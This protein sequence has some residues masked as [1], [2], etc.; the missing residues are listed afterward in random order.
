[1][2][3]DFCALCGKK[4]GL[5]HHHLIPRSEDGT[6]EPDN[7]LTL[8]EEHHEFIHQIRPGTWNNHTNL[9]KQGIK[10]SQEIGVTFGRPLRL[11]TKEEYDEIIKQKKDGVGFR[12]LAKKYRIG[13]GTLRKL[14]L[15]P[16][17]I[18]TLTQRKEKQDEILEK[19][20]SWKE[21]SKS[22]K[23]REKELDKIM[24]ISENLRMKIENC[25][26]EQS[27]MVED[28]VIKKIE[29]TFKKIVPKIVEKELDKILD[30][31]KKTVLNQV[32]TYKKFLEKQHKKINE[33]AQ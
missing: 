22:V 9:V 31:S 1:M 33:I 14:I 12:K 15:D 11:F 32:N 6:D 30:T 13:V 29:T 16:M 18:E 2:K 19:Y 25:V 21:Y 23:R 4:E 8:C 10:K 20:G 17:Y 3:L 5:H 7:L 26:N 28:K 24:Q 27:N